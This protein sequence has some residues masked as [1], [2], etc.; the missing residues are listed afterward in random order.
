MPLPVSTPQRKRRCVRQSSAGSRG[1]RGAPEGQPRL[2]RRSSAHPGTD[3]GGAGETYVTSLTRA[4]WPCASRILDIMSLGAIYVSTAF[5]VFLR[6]HLPSAREE[7]YFSCI[8][9]KRIILFLMVIAHAAPWRK[10]LVSHAAAMHAS[11]GC[12]QCG[13]LPGRLGA[14]VRDRPRARRPAACLDHSWAQRQT[15]YRFSV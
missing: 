2:Y 1:S 3:G 4:G 7:L 12:G 15:V 8:S 14:A 6:W 13:E 5:S 9:L 11:A 10:D